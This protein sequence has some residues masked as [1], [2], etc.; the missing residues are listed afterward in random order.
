MSMSG[1]FEGRVAIVTGA[2]R[3]MGLAVA[4]H[5][6][7]QGARLCLWDLEE[8][9]LNRAAATLGVPSDRLRVS[10]VDV[11]QSGAVEQ[12][13]ADDAKAMGR[14]DILINCAGIAG[15]NALVEAFPPDAWDR[16]MRVNLGGVFHC[17]RAVVPFMR[18][19]DYGRIVNVASVAGKEG[20]PN[21]SAYSASKAGV[22]SLTKSLGKE[23][24]TTGIRVNAITPAVIKTEMLD[25]VT[26][27]QVAYMLAKIPMGRMGTVDEVAEMAMFLASERCSYSTAAVFDMT[28]GRATY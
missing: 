5:L 23:L 19:N 12:A 17:C 16:V 25:D 3:G 26:D 7:D 20:N 15:P 22:I 18:E 10:A 8:E 28:G 27:E 9:A 11:S 14:I 24:A 1:E 2:A 21:A 6:L 4:R 13:A